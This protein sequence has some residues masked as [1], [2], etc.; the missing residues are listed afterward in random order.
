MCFD[1]NISTL[2]YIIISYKLDITIIIIDQVIINIILVKNKLIFVK[3][4]KKITN[5]FKFCTIVAF[6]LTNII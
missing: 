6:P 2:I 5:I 4:L 1:Y 3:N